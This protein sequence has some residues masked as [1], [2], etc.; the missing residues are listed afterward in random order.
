MLITRLPLPGLGTLA[1][2]LSNSFWALLAARAVTGAGGA[3]ILTL[4][5]IITTDLI[6]LRERGYYQGLM[7]TL[8]GIGAAG[9][10]PIA[11]WISDNYGWVRAVSL[12]LDEVA[13]KTNCHVPVPSCSKPLSSPNSRS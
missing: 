3:G 2:A 6:S 4:S 9:G 7:M 13:W 8:F 10:G 1:C 5:S 12:S 11:G